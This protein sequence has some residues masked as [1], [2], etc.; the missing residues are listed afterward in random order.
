[1]LSNEQK[2]AVETTEGPLLII[3]GP[4]S[5]KTFTLVERILFLIKNKNVQPENIM[6]AT[7]TEKAASE[8]ITR[9]SNKLHDENIQFNLNEMYIGTLHSICLRIL[10]E[11]REF[12]RLK[13]N[14]N[15]L[16][17]F[18]QQYLIYQKM[19]R[20]LEIE[21]ISELLNIS[22][23]RWKQSEFLLKWINKLSE[24]VV[25]ID[26]MLLHENDQIKV[27][28]K[29]YK[30]YQEILHEENA[31]DFSTIQLETLNLLTNYKE[32]KEKYNDIIHYLMIDEFQDTNTI[33]EQLVFLL[34]GDK[35]NICVVGDDDQGLYRFRGAT[36][37]NI[38]EFP[39]NFQDGECKQ[40]ELSMNYRSNPPIVQFYNNWMEQNNWSHN[41]QTYRFKKKIEAHES[42]FTE[43]KTVVK[44]SGENGQKDWES[45]VYLFL[46]ALKNQGKLTDW[47]QVAF[48]F[49]S[50]KNPKVLALSRYLEERNIPVYSP[51]S[52]LYFERAEVRLAIGAIL[53][54]F[55]QYGECRKWNETAYLPEW[56]YYDSCL[57]EFANELRKTENKDLLMWCKVKAKEHYTLNQNTD[58]GFTGLFYQLLQFDLFSKMIS[59]NVFTVKDSREARNLS[60]FSNMLAKFEYLHHISVLTPNNIEDSI[61]KLFNQYMR[62]LIQGGINE[63]EDDSE[64]APSGCVSFLTIHQSKGLEFPVVLVGSLD[65]APRKQYTGLDEI[66]QNEFYSKPL[67]EP[68]D[69][70]KYYDFYRLYYTAFSRAQNLLALTCQ[71]NVASGQGT[72]NVP[73]RTFIESY[74]NLKS[75][76][77]EPSILNL[78][79]AKVK[80]INIKREYSF[81]SHINLFE[82]CA[83]QYKFYKELG[84]SP[85]RQGAT[86]FGTLVHQTIEDIHKAALRGETNLLTTE[87]IESWFNTNYQYLSK[88]ERVYLAD[89]TKNAALKQVEKYVDKQQND[90]SKIQEAE[91]DVSLVKDNY[92]LKGTIDLIK[93]EGDSVELIDFKAEKKPNLE[94]NREAIDRYKKQLEVYAH[95]VEERTNYSVSKMH[96]YYTGEENSNPYVT[97]NKDSS[98]INHTIK[99]F[100]A[101]VERIERHDYTIK[102]RPKKHCGN[103]DMRFY[104]DRNL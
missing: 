70:T 73:S 55:R 76:R 16:D 95:L 59:E 38:L 13:K 7:F 39:N 4:G 83:L 53:F 74:R 29:C 54:L 32:I 104:C 93:G 68:I 63:Y 62:F 92:I 18:D 35:K 50:V 99:S 12:T 51:R 78:D 97:F 60:L 88:R 15:M 67:F 103:C 94:E 65:A 21:D 81:T 100:D 71:E 37:R 69:R 24:E 47:N 86:I 23:S 52:N 26:E 42:N 25:D 34:A 31:L 57:M 10:E 87:N 45:E 46:Q 49:K 9:I 90:W 40:V 91:V 17:Q 3:A 66:L 20:F 11:N 85:V 56:E 2:I 44:V 8:L 48:L 22:H 14:Y 28:G 27:L 30:V 58:Y 5:G 82:T 96:I 64:Y 77:E 19:R 72:R 101:I 84:F 33:Q 89:S 61:V 80:D 102:E 41:N 75:W 43:S 98:V 79:L 6:V 1:M 36:I